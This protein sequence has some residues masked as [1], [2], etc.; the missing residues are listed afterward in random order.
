MV[1]EVC[2]V[3]YDEEGQVPVILDYPRFLAVQKPCPNCGIQ[4][5][6]SPERIADKR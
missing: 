6:P 5:E 3:E 4:R 2:S 1:C